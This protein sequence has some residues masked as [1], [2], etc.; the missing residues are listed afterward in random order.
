MILTMNNAWNFMDDIRDV[1]RTNEQNTYHSRNME[2]TDDVLNMTFD[3]PGLSKKDIKVWVDSKD[4]ILNIE[5]DNE[6]RT[7]NKQYKI[8]EDWN[9]DKVEAKVLNGVLTLSIPKIEE[10]K[11]KRIEV[12]IK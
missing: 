2:I 5:G 8:S 12:T 11:S 1:I 10:K 4:R 6:E 3:V 9:A 7:F